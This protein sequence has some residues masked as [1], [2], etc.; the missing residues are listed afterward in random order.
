MAPA[1]PNAPSAGDA[2]QRDTSV[3]PNPLEGPQRL[4]TRDSIPVR[5]RPFTESSS[6]IR[7]QSRPRT[8]MP[9]TLSQTPQS[10][11]RKLRTNLTQ[12]PPSY[13][14]TNRQLQNA[15]SNSSRCGKRFTQHLRST[16]LRHWSAASYREASP[17]P[18]HAAILDSVGKTPRTAPLEK[19]VT[20]AGV[21]RAAKDAPRCKAQPPR[22]NKRLIRLR[23]DS[24]FLTNR[25]KFNWQ[26]ATSYI[27]N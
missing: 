22:N 8:K 9:T 6:P 12:P 15:L 5:T 14:R 24:E 1:P 11:S 26:Y 7:Q 25:S 19:T 17:A 13:A 21:T 18:D 4:I 27:Y 16:I 2:P 20:F 23:K 3:S 10:S